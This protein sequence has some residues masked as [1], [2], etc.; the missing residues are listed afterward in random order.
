MRKIRGPSK[1]GKQ[2]LFLFLSWLW[3]KDDN[4]RTRDS[5][6]LCSILFRTFEFSYF[7][8]LFPVSNILFFLAP[9][10]R[11]S[12]P[13]LTNV[14]VCLGP[15]VEQLFRY[16][17]FRSRTNI[18]A[19]VPELYNEYLHIKKIS[20]WTIFSIEWWQVMIIIALWRVTLKALFLWNI[21]GIF[22]YH[23]WAGD[24]GSTLKHC[25]TT[26]A[27]NYNST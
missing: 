7:G 8:N 25:R 21:S 3:V 11:T 1:R 5:S 22:A 6:N 4:V 10:P 2:K 26:F 24:T 13:F 17:F 19:A 12:P 23:L 20:W 18:I 15:C 16:S 9:P 27:L 14:V